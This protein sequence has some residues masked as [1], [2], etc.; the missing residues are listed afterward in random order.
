MK[1]KHK[2]RLQSL[3][4]GLP[5][6]LGYA[7]YYFFQRNLGGLRDVNPT[8]HITVGIKIAKCIRQQGQSIDSK[9]FL[10]I[11]TGRQITVP[12]VLWLLGASRTITVDINPYLKAELIFDAIAY[13]RKHQEEIKKLFEESQ[14]SVLA[15]R[16]NQ[17]IKIERN[18]DRLF[19]LTN[20]Q[21]LA[22]ADASRLKV[23]SHTIDYHISHTTL[24]HIPIESLRS[25]LREGKRLLRPEGLFVHGIDFSDHFAHSDDSISAINFLQYSDEEWNRWAGNKFMYHNRLRVDDFERLVSDA[26][27]RILRMD[28]SVDDRARK[29][30]EGGFPLNDRFRNKSVET[31][32]TTSAWLVAADDVT[33][34]AREALQGAYP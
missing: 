27:L 16:F 6:S 33:H 5:S 30:L 9:A 34:S 7:T 3:I 24:E 31:N 11:G 1:W 22:P 23:E 21:Y 4:A 15:D 25:I 14:I 12:I 28:V 26:N 10:E 32:A 19:Q 29:E 20:I 2:S 17:L 13:M 8:N 18:L